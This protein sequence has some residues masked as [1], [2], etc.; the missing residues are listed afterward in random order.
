MKKNDPS[1]D[2]ETGK[3]PPYVEVYFENDLLYRGFLIDVVVEEHDKDSSHYAVSC[4]NGEIFDVIVDLRKNSKTYGKYFSI[5]LSQDS[6]CSIYIPPNFAHGFLC[7][8]KT[9]AVY[10]K[11]TN[12]RDKNSEQT[13]KW[14]D[15]TLKIK[16]PIKKP[17]LSKK[18]KM[19]IKFSDFK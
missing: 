15:E 12:Y 13:I 8:T 17:I 6:D 7:L 5:K 19:G 18:D 11:C 1:D 14:N 3:L 10:Y 4:I 9:C 2:V 16:W